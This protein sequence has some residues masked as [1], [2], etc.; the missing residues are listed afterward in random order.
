M[1]CGNSISD[2]SI[3][4]LFVLLTFGKTTTPSND[5]I[6]QVDVLLYSHQSPPLSVWLNVREKFDSCENSNK[7]ETTIRLCVFAELVFFFSE[8]RSCCLL[9]VST[10]F[11]EFN[12]EN[13]LNRFRKSTNC[14]LF[15]IEISGQREI[16]RNFIG[17][18]T[19]S[20]AKK[21]KQEAKQDSRRRNN[22]QQRSTQRRR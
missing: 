14:S 22:N 19:E 21:K 5:K 12:Q 13:C 7:R 8:A 11:N 1:C 6:Q 4:A 15:C 10:F 17:N 18:Y 3:S 16:V 20:K 9:Q 2:S